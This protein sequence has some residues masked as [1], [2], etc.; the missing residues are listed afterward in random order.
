MQKEKIN[1]N[2]NLISEVQ[3]KEIEGKDGKVQVANFTL[4]KKTGK[5]GEKKK[6]YYNCNVYGDKAEI[7]RDFEQ[8]DFIHV[9]GYFKTVKKEDKEYI[10]FIVSYLNKIEKEAKNDEEVE[11]AEMDAQTMENE[12]IKEEK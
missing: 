7:A 3:F 1:L 9:Y 11:C 2:G 12:E 4:F 5:E 6:E 8:G 10:N